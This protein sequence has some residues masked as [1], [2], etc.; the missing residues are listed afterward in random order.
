M[1]SMLFLVLFVYAA[2]NIVIDYRQFQQQ[3]ELSGFLKGNAA[4]LAWMV[5]TIEIVVSVFL[6]IPRF[7][8]LGLYGS[9]GLLLLFTGYI[10]WVLHFSAIVPCSC[11]GVISVLGWWG[12]LYFNLCLLALAFL[13]IFLCTSRQKRFSDKN[14]T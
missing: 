3:L 13:G 4:A 10:L 11:G 5:P 14:T 7:R 6:L 8:V 2:S 12:H 1:V 9:L